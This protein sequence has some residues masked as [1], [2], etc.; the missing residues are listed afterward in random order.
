M[1]ASKLCELV[2]SSVLKIQWDGCSRKLSKL[3][4]AMIEVYQCT[5]LPIYVVLSNLL[6]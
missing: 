4:I 1:N 5:L 3:K 2:D 6:K